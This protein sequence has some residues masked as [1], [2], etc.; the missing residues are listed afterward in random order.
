MPVIK[1][2]V[3]F[4]RIKPLLTV[5][6]GELKLL[7]VAR[8][9]QQGLKRLREEMVGLAPLEKL[10]VI[11]IR[12]PQPA[13]QLVEDLSQRLA[14]PRDEILLV[15]TGTV[16]SCQGGPGVTAAFCVEAG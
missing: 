9:Y 4:F 2:A 10:A 16:L 3:G 5:V 14:Y 13:E 7:S 15:E 1:K 6:E 11:H 8:S 12:R